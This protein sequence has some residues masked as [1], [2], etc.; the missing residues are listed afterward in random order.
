ME[1]ASVCSFEEKLP[2]E[3]SLYIYKEADVGRSTLIP[4]YQLISHHSDLRPIEIWVPRSESANA[5]TDMRQYLI[6]SMSSANTSKKSFLGVKYDPDSSD[7]LQPVCPPTMD[8]AQRRLPPSLIC[9]ERL[10]LGYEISV[11]AS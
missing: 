1:T 9:H 11:K 4:S 5:I 8:K 10:Y 6:L 2:E 7:T 3:H